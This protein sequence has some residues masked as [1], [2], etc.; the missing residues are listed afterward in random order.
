MPLLLRVYYNA[1]FGALGGLLGWMLYG[2][3]GDKNPASDPAFLFFTWQDLNSF[4][5]GALIGGAI[6][7]LIVSVEAIRDGALV[8]FARLASYGVV[9]GAVGGALGMYI[10]D[11]V[12]YL[13]VKTENRLVEILARGIGWTL[14]ALALG[15]RGGIAAR[16]VGPLSAGA[17]GA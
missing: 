16:R 8:R 1:V 7:L 6:G 10:G 13:L 14:L 2:V 4:L 9:L 5:G 11:E 12:N 3:F 17:L 15:M